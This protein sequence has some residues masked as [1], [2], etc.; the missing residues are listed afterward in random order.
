MQGESNEMSSTTRDI[1]KEELIYVPI[2]SDEENTPKYGGIKKDLLVK[3]LSELEENYVVC[4][5][6]GGVLRGSIFTEKGYKCSSC[7]SQ[8]DVKNSLEVE[9]PAIASIEV[10]CPMRN[11]GCD[12][13][14]TVSTI[15]EHLENCEFYPVACKLNC[16]MLLTQDEMEDHVAKEC[17]NR[18]IECAYC[19]TQTKVGEMDDHLEECKEHPV[20][21]PNDCE[22]NEMKRKELEDH[23][24]T[25]CALA[26]TNCAYSQYGCEE[27]ITRMDLDQHEKEFQGDHLNLMNAHIKRL[28]STLIRNT[29]GGIMMVVDSLADKMK[30]GESVRIVSDP[31]YSCL[32]KFEAILDMNDRNKKVMGAYVRVLK[33]EWDEQLSWPFK[34]RIVFRL[35]N[36]KKEKRSIVQTVD[37][38]G[39][40]ASFEKPGDE[41][42]PSRGFSVFAS[43]EQIR[44]DKFSRG[45]SIFIK[46]S[47]ERYST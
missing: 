41:P 39:E 27:K 6:C 36:K 46:I 13:K 8:A 38:Q 26:V 14:E 1:S 43:H 29:N 33:G 7:V 40:E 30:R 15:E 2:N 9:Q 19:F 37:T 5:S 11:K 47:V 22:Q 16:E 18:E 42:N 4:S 20:I 23:V 32:Y 45:D 12:R 24:N 34:G 3:E 21:C 31:F 44:Q 28:E 10:Y 25:K 35:L 17:E